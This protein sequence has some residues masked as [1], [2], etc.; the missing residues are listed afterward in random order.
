MTSCGKKTT[1]SKN[2][3]TKN[4]KNGRG[5]I[6]PTPDLVFCANA[7][8]NSK[9]EIPDIVLTC[10]CYDEIFNSDV[11]LE[12]RF[13]QSLAVM[14]NDYET[15]EYLINDS[16]ID[17]KNN[18]YVLY[19]VDGNNNKKEYKKEMTTSI[20]RPDLIYVNEFNKYFIQCWFL[21]N[22]KVSIP[23]KYFDKNEGEVY[24][25][26]FEE[27]KTTTDEKVLV[28]IA[29]KYTKDEN[30]IKIVAPENSFSG[31]GLN[32]G[33]TVEEIFREA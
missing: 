29:I 22:D 11:N 3:D 32:E 12:M 25:S 2:I 5:S 14:E 33:K 30:G 13:G 8:Y 21:H 6:S 20:Y 31:K 19:V 17:K 15:T 24:L 1:T 4:N 7:M 23:K 28:T 16:L 26:V 10:C 27:S 9:E 18:N